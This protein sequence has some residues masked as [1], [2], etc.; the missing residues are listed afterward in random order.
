MDKL[1]ESYDWHAGPLEVASLHLVRP[2]LI[3]LER[4]ERPTL[5]WTNLQKK[6]IEEQFVEQ[7]NR[8]A[9]VSYFWTK[10]KYTEDVTNTGQMG[11]LNPGDIINDKEKMEEYKKLRKNYLESIAE[12][13]N[14]FRK[15]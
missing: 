12:F 4:W 7:S 1:I 10:T 14:E 2:E 8:E 9:A 11:F 6:L 5:S 15:D 3:H 13:I